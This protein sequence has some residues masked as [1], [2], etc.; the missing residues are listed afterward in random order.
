MRLVPEPFRSYLREAREV[1]RGEETT[2]QA[3]GRLCQLCMRR[4]GAT[5]RC[6]RHAGE[7]TARFRDQA[8]ARY[9]FCCRATT[10]T[11]RTSSRRGRLT[12]WVGVSATPCWGLATGLAARKARLGGVS[13]LCLWRHWPLATALTGNGLWPGRRVSFLLDRPLVKQV[14]R[15]SYP[16]TLAP[17]PPHRVSDYHGPTRPPFKK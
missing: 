3:R 1:G 2:L 12:R 17:T 13:Q 9:Y 7:S 15:R 8:L 5:S 11:S 10:S 4:P 6:S 16:C 14:A